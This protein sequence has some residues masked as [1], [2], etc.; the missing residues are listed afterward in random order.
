MRCGLLRQ[1]DLGSASSRAGYGRSA[2][3]MK[4]FFLRVSRR[5][6]SCGSQTEERATASSKSCKWGRKFRSAWREGASPEPEEEMKGSWTR[7]CC[8]GKVPLPTWAVC[9]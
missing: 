5:A 4:D 3:D 8:G 9:D 6:T 1:K 7:L 2:P